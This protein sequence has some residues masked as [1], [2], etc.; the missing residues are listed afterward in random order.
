MVQ[1]DGHELLE[2]YHLKDFGSALS[3]IAPEVI[4]SARLI[5]GGFPAQYGDR[6]GGVLDLT[7][8]VPRSETHRTL[9]L[10]VLHAEAGGSG[11]L[12]GDRGQWLG[13]LR[14]GALDLA[15]SVA[16][17]ERDPSFADAFVKI[18]W[19]RTPSRSFRGYTLLSSDRLDFAERLGDLTSGESGAGGD[20]DERQGLVQFATRYFSG[21]LWGSHQ[22]VLQSGLSVETRA[23]LS[24]VQRDR[25]GDEVLDTG[26]LSLRDGRK[27]DVVGLAQAWSLRRGD[28]Q[29]FQWGFEARALDVDYDYRNQRSL[30]DPLAVV[31]FRPPQSSTTLDRRFSGEQLGAY[32]T[33]RMRLGAPLTL[34]LGLRFDENTIL[35]DEYV[36]PRS[37]LTYQLGAD[38]RLTAAWGHFYQ[39]QR[40]YELQVEDGEARFFPSERSEHRILGFEHS[41]SRDRDPQAAVRRREPLTL[42]VELYEHRIRRPRPRYE[43]LF[44]PISLVPEAEADRFRI[45]PESALAQGIELLLSAGGRRWDAFM[46]YS[47]ARIE[48]R[49]GGRDVPRAVDQRDAFKLDFAYRTPGKWDFSVAAEVR[50]GWP[51]TALR[52]ELVGDGD[53][54]A[55]VPV[56][57]PV[58]GERLGTYRRLDGRVSRHFSLRRGELEVYLDVQN[59]TNARNIRGFEFSFEVE[60]GGVRVVRD[61]KLW[62]RL[63]PSFGLR[64]SF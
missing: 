31:G 27:L 11:P 15:A 30:S 14:Y 63:V 58:Y 44:D 47:R 21:D 34:E 22:A 56:I 7:S 20:G 32:V 29:D 62:S 64:W 9:A 17:E 23:S 51:T 42:R 61:D 16:E 28:V 49:V 19:A 50:S 18:G 3:S 43:N 35:D 12:P 5:T 1:V 10:S 24:R 4:G 52:V 60:D 26:E 13:T 6:M 59:L 55:V 57:G 38:S 54:P 2:P 40:V 45:A 46:S 48:D 33:G 41:F 8:R 36:S 37:S 25:R 53:D 39:S